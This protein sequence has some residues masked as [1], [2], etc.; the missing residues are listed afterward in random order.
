MPRVDVILLDLRG[1]G[2]PNAGVTQELER[3]VALVS[4]RRVVA[5]MDDT[6]DMGALRGALKRASAAA[7]A[8]SPLALNMAPALLVVPSPTTRAGLQQLLNALGAAASDSSL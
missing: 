6:T 1:F 5:I 7:P 8:S 3:L 4:L 2:P